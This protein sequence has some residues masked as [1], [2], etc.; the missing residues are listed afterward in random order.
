MGSGALV[1]GIRPPRFPNQPVGDDGRHCHN[2]LFDY[3]KY[4]GEREVYEPMKQQIE[5]QVSKFNEFLLDGQT[6]QQGPVTGEPPD[7]ICLSHLRWG[8][9]FQRPKHLMSRFA[10]DRRVY[11]VE[12]PY[13]EEG[14]PRLVKHLCPETGVNIIAPYLP[15]N[16]SSEAKN[17]LMSALLDE[18][19]RTEQLN[20]VVLWYYTPMA[21]EFSNHLERAVTVYDC[22]DELS[23]FKGAP[24]EL[25]ER[26][27]QLMKRADLMFTGGVTLF[28]FKKGNHSRIYPFPSGVDVPHFRHARSIPEEPADQ[29]SIPH[30]RLGY[31]RAIDERFDIELIRASARL[32]PE[33]HFVLVRAA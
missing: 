31:A 10:R 18:L 33:W 9:V 6:Q 19:V 28:E 11:F 13:F 20:S 4:N 23:G 12:E 7:L 16:L 25:R 15:P 26:E 2:G 32:N 22:M 3:A 27:D 5:R 8:F 14:A 24:P 21:L 29:Q 17:T 1:E 30:P